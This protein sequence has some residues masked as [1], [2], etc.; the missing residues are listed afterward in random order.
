MCN[1]YA[2]IPKHSW[3]KAAD[4]REFVVAEL[5]WEPGAKPGEV[6]VHTI[7]IVEKYS[8]NV[9]HRP[10]EEFCELVDKGM[11]KAIKKRG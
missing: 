8:P 5:L 9:I 10:W 7:G 2:L 1:Y 6:I 4:G 11:M 3:W